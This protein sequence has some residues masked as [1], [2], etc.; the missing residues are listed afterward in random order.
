ME[1]TKVINEKLKEYQKEWFQQVCEPWINKKGSCPEKMKK[2]VEKRYGINAQYSFSQPFFTSV[3]E[4]NAK[5]VVMFV[6]QETNG[7][8]LIED[9]DINGIKQWNIDNSQKSGIDI[10]NAQLSLQVNTSTFWRFICSIVG[11]VKQTQEVGIVWNNL[12]KIHYRVSNA[13]VKNQYRDVDCVTLYSEDEVE[14]NCKVEQYGKTLLQLEIETI[15]PDLT[16]FLTG[17]NY[18]ESIEVALGIA[19]IAKPTKGKPVVTI[20]DN[21]IWTY[22]PSF[23]FRDKDIMESAKVEIIARIKTLSGKNVV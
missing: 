10:L 13:K 21:M 4:N 16:V 5:P 3:E 1:D 9:F 22:H 18:K 12:D 19:L 6:G 14:L 15:K 17:P 2:W 20:N 8:G 7:W 11:T 23:L